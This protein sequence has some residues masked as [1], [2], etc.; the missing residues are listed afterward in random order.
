MSFA[1]ILVGLE[2]NPLKTQSILYYPKLSA[3]DVWI[4]LIVTDLL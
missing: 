2:I 3:Q 4:S 1:K